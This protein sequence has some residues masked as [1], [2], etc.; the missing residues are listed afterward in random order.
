MNKK[1]L[2]AFALATAFNATQAM[3]NQPQ[4]KNTDSTFFIGGFPM[5]QPNYLENCTFKLPQR[6]D[7]NKTFDEFMQNENSRLHLAAAQG[8]ME[9]CE[10][11]LAAN[12]NLYIKNLSRATPLWVAAQHG[13]LHVVHLLL[14][15]GTSYCDAKNESLYTAAQNGHIAVCT[16]LIHAKAKIDANPNETCTPL[17]AAAKFKQKETVKFFLEHGADA[18]R[19]HL[20]GYTPIYKA[21]LDNPD[22]SVC[23][24]LIAYG[25]TE[26]IKGDELNQGAID[27]IKNLIQQCE[28][29]L[30]TEVR[31]QLFDT[32]INFIPINALA[33]IVV[34]YVD[35]IDP[36]GL[37]YVV[38][39]NKAQAA[40]NYKRLC[41]SPE[42]Q[43]FQQM[44]KPIQTTSSTSPAD[45]EIKNDE[46]G[47]PVPAG[48]L[49]A[50]VSALQEQ[51]KEEDTNNAQ[52]L[53]D[54]SNLNLN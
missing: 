53:N 48:E 9:Q 51:I 34:D 13:H 38:A 45:S 19:D 20:H 8:D 17:Y 15:H 23:R 30:S 49:P 41:E 33:T 42:A 11:L 31:K 10:N 2:I 27:Y 44:Q 29:E 35:L 25:A 26:K 22:E 47:I 46:N 12:A 4:Q 52:N 50:A 7:V 6:P 36:K 1:F 16:L 40:L 14:V 54:N 43:E 32:I 28:R 18:T 5:Q 39:H 3:E 24:L 37:A 21:A